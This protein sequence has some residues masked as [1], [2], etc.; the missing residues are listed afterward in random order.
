MNIDESTIV[1]NAEVDD[2]IVKELGIDQI[3]NYWERVRFIEG[4]QLS[5]ARLR[6]LENIRAVKKR[7]IKHF[8]IFR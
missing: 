5:L 2:A 6:A 8:S 1:G 7:T 4:D 3:P